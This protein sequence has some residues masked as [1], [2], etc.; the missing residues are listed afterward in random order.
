M[1]VVPNA[2]LIRLYWVLG[3]FR[4]STD[5]LV[6]KFLL[7]F[8]FYP[9]SIGTKLAYEITLM[10]WLKVPKVHTIAVRIWTLSVH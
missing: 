9:C 6:Q 8:Y 1:Y 5:T 3:D 2:T 4:M 10:E 7:V